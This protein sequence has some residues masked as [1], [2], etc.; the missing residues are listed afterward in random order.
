M[1]APVWRHEDLGGIVARI[2]Y[3]RSIR[4]VLGQGME[5]LTVGCTYTFF[6]ASVASL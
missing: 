5:M 2:T 3:Y 4:P 1:E 6:R